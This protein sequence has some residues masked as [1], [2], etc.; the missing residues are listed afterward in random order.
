MP[1]LIICSI[2]PR[3]KQ[4]CPP[5]PGSNHGREVMR[6]L[7]RCKMRVRLQ[8][9]KLL[10]SGSSKG[11]EPLQDRVGPAAVE[12]HWVMVF[13]ISPILNPEPDTAVQTADTSSTSVTFTTPT[14][15]VIRRITL[16]VAGSLIS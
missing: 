12:I 7:S 13:A 16:P 4:S 6:A 2:T 5:E 15:E 9:Q 3:A 14:G 11:E 10:G 8:G 1:R